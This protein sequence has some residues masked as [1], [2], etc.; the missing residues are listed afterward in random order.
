VLYQRGNEFSIRVDG[1]ELMTSSACHSEREMAR[2]ALERLGGRDARPRLL[3]GGLGMGFTARAA[4][5]ALPSGAHVVIAEIAP[6][7]VAW[8]RGPL[9]HLA[10]NPLEDRRV[11][12]EMR[13]VGRVIAE[14][15]ACFDAI[16]LDVDNGPRGLAREANQGL[17]TG[18]GLAAARRA[19]RSGGLLVV[20]S[21]SPDGRF[22]KRLR[23]AGYAAE[24]LQVPAR[25]PGAAGTRHTIFFGRAPGAA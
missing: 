23:E 8:N 24:S 6:A 2:L 25:G 11:R 3:I 9:G 18:A 12:V 22:E 19:L 15:A 7:V 20:W 1:R 13:D 21:A 10:A 4:L 16:L 5:D 14:A 17:Y